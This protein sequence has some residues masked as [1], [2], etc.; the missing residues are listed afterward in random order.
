MIVQVEPSQVIEDVRMVSDFA[1]HEFQF[2]AGLIGLMQF[3]KRYRQRKSCPQ[4][5][6]RIAVRA[7]RN[8]VTATRIG[9]AFRAS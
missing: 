5:Q 6:R 8:S 3:E 9:P 4:T 1:A 7:A 2:A